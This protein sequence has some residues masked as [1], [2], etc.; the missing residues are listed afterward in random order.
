[1]KVFVND[2][3]ITFVKFVVVQLNFLLL[4]LNEI[5]FLLQLLETQN[6]TAE[7][8]LRGVASI[9]LEKNAGV[10]GFI[11]GVLLTPT[12]LFYNWLQLALAFV[13]SVGGGNRNFKGGN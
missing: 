8:H 12:W 1:M 3:V 10:A 5:Q 2:F 13:A 9:L 6:A 11:V 4:Q 7:E